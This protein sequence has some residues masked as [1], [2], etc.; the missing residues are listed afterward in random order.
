MKLPMSWCLPVS[1]GITL[2]WIIAIWIKV[3]S[4]LLFLKTTQKP[5]QETSWS[6]ILSSQRYSPSEM[7]K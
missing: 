7:Y 5:F 6:L 3:K 1:P 4:M 2:I